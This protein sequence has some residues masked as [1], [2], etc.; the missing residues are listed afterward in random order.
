MLQ[1]AYDLLQDILGDPLL[2]D[3]PEDVDTEDVRC[4]IARAKGHV[5]DLTLLRPGDNKMRVSVLHNAR[6]SDLQRI[7]TKAIK[8]STPDLPK[9]YSWRS[10]WRRYNLS[11]GSIKLSD[12]NRM[13][14]HYGVKNN[15]TVSFTKRVAVTSTHAPPPPHR[16]R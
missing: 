14:I 4:Q 1:E 3:L 7:V 9:A 10:M 5:I 15:D 8:R 16:R 6:V 12:R 11:V 13:L 2:A